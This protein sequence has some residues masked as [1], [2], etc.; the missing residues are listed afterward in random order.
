MRTVLKV[1][2]TLSW[3]NLVF[4][5]M[6]TLLCL[7]MTLVMGPVVLVPAVL[8]CAIPLNSYAALQLHKSIRQP[9]VKLSNQ[10]PAG[11]RFVGFVALFCGL[12]LCA[13]GIVAALHPDS[14]VEA[15]RQ[16][17][18][19]MGVKEPAG[20]TPALGRKWAIIVLILGLGVVV[21]VMLNFR[22][23]RWY[24]LVHQSDAP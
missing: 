17:Y 5:G 7:L 4:W 15:M 19:Q 3:F 6:I 21:N 2:S 13:D 16:S 8:L 20:L 23:L 12:L 10:T 9:V 22:L 14:V 1:A 24:Y 18:S 11:I